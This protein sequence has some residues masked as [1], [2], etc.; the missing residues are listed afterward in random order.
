ASVSGLMLLE[1]HLSGTVIICAI[2]AIMMFV[3]GTDVKW[4]ALGGTLLVVAIVGA[5]ILF[6]DLVPYA[7]ERIIAW[8]HPE[9]DLQG[10]GY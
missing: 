10:K 4:F 7:S 5:V 3:G 9:L 8:R 2:G 6:P 1:P